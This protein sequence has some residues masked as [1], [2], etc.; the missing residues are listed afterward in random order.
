ML[1][2]IVITSP[3]NIVTYV[4]ESI[5]FFCQILNGIPKPILIW[6]TLSGYQ[7][8]TS[9][10]KK[11]DEG[12]VLKL[13]EISKSHEGEYICVASNVAGI[14]EKRVN[15]TVKGKLLFH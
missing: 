6:K 8:P 15:L 12:L 14:Q 2:E 10:L 9:Q 1:P 11:V 4:G 7:V 3:I 5:S 13:S